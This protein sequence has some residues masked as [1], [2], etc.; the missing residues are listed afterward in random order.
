MANYR[1]IFIKKASEEE[2]DEVL[3]TVYVDDSG[4]DRQL[5]L[6]GK[7][8]RIAPPICLLADKTITERV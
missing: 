7:A 6:V 8:F 5:S 2:K 3:G 1:V 4:S